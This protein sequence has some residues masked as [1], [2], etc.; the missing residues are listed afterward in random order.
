ML[1]TGA[2]SGIGEATA[3]RL[4]RSGWRV[5]ATVRKPGDAPDGTEE[6]LLDITDAEQIAAAAAHIDD[7]HALVNNAGIAIAS[8]LELIPLDELRRQLEVNVLGQVAVTQAFLPHLR[9]ARGRIVFVGSI[10]GRS[11]LPFLGAYAASKHALEAI[12]DSLR[13][14]LTPWSIHVAIVEPATIATPMW[15]KGPA[16]ADE[17]QA[18]LT[19]SSSS[20]Y[21]E[22]LEAFRRAAEAAGRRAQP[23]ERVAAVVGRALTSDRPRARYVVGRDARIRAT[24]E[25][26]PDRLRDRAYERLLLRP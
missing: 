18:R 22:R 15:T 10:A 17:I 12:A 21:R 1:V 19:S 6:I 7:L 20:L 2:S 8:P 4:A 11:A 25:R 14:E 13:V 3:R 24:I 5:F 16:T 9:R 26:L 23:A